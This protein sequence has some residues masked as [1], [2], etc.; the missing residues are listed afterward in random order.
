MPPEKIFS[1]VSPMLCSYYHLRAVVC[2]MFI[3]FLLT[4][5]IQVNGATYIQ[6]NIILEFSIFLNNIVDFSFNI[7]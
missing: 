5:K 6:H 3:E 1:Q 7:D 2:L 4:L